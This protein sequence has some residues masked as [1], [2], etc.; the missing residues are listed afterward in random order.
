MRRRA[1]RRHAAPSRRTSR[2]AQGGDV[3]RAG[4]V[5]RHASRSSSPPAARGCGGPVERLRVGERDGDPPARHEPLSSAA[6][7]SATT[8]PPSRRVMRSASWSAS[9]RYWVVSSTVTPSP[10]SSRTTSHMALRLRGSRPVVGSSRKSTRGRPTR[11]IARSR[12]RRM[13]PENVL[14]AGRRR[15][16]TGRT[17]R[18]DRPCRV[19]ISAGQVVQARHQTQV[20]LAGEQVVDGGELPGEADRGAHPQRGR[21]R[22]R[23]RRPGRCPRRAP[24]GSRAC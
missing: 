22:R 17:A 2:S 7:P 21:S 18:A 8:S 19:R 23:A 15:P 10:T 3:A 9:S 5:E 16:R 14:T 1:R 24:T 4:D 6:V 12:R 13:P 11:P 20:L